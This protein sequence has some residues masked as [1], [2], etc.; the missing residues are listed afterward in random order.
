[1]KRNEIIVYLDDYETTLDIVVRSNY[2][3]IDRT[4]DDMKVYVRSDGGEVECTHI[5]SES[6]LDEFTQMLFN[7]LYEWYDE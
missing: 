2:D 7:E 6:V 3:S 4:M 1:M 5:F